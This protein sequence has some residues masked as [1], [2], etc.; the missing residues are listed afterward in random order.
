MVGGA[1]GS[2]QTWQRF[3]LVDDVIDVTELESSA[4][5]QP[6]LCLCHESVVVPIMLKN[7]ITTGNN[8]SGLFSFL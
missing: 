1:S 4:T 6:R 2:L 7:M 5:S 3:A 8:V